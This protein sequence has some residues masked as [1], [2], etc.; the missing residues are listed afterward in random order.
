L[1]TVRGS[2]STRESI[3][4]WKPSTPRWMGF[5][6]DDGRRRS[7][8]ITPA[9][10][11]RHQESAAKSASAGNAFLFTERTKFVPQM[12]L[13]PQGDRSGSAMRIVQ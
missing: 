6:K 3:R 4:S 13:Y 7:R 5:S 11:H 9:Y 2:V 12:M 8:K 1:L 10:G